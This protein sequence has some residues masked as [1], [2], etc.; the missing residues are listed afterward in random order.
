M[1]TLL[2]ALVL[3][4]FTAKRTALL[5]LLCAIA[6]FL[7]IIHTKKYW[8][9]ILCAVG[10]LGL[11]IVSQEMDYSM[12]EYAITRFDAINYD[13]GSG[14]LSILELFWND[15]P[16]WSF[17]EIVFGHGFGQ[18]L[19][20]YE[21]VSAHNDYAEITY[22]HGFLAFVCFLWLNLKIYTMIWRLRGT[23]VFAPFLL[24][25]IEYAFYTMVAN[26]YFYYTQ[27]SLLFIMIALLDNQ[28]QHYTKQ[29]PKDPYCYDP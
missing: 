27:T 21:F 24:F 15:I 29:P 11:L 3:A 1:Y 22:A 8:I 17:L 13:R 28:Y 6:A 23:K 5:V 20:N 14:R 7:L 9:T 2:I 4:L 25:G 16:S 10:G 12:F 26:I 19:K 18:F